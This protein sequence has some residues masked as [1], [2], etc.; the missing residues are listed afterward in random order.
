[1][2]QLQFSPDD[3]LKALQS[4]RASNDAGTGISS[5]TGMGATNPLGNIGGGLKPL[6]LG[7]N[8]PTA[9]LGL[10]GIG[11]LGNLWSAFQA[12]SMA[13][14]QFGLQRDVA[15]ANLNNQISSY[16]TAL[17]SKA[18]NASLMRGD[19]GGAVSSYVDD[20]LQRHALRRDSQVRNGATPATAQ[21]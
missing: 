5:L 2:N 13:K 10:Q 16:N 4:Y 11:A 3:Y 14:K 8:M 1:M 9:Q 12:N 7:W 18:R 21:G 15:N 20:Y 19:T 17:E 6:E